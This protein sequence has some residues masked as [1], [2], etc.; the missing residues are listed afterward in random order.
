MSPAQF[1]Q[2]DELTSEKYAMLWNNAIY[3]MYSSN[4]DFTKWRQSDSSWANIKIGSTD[5]TLGQI[6]C[7]ITSVS[8]L[9]KKSNVDVDNIYPSN[10]GTFTIALNNNYGFVYFKK[11]KSENI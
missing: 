1:N 10:T 4:G 2:L 3:G 6:G 5:K 9:I 7:L 8:I 11:I